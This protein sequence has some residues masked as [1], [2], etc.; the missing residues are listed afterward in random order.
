MRRHLMLIILAAAPALAGCHQHWSYAALKGAQV[1]LPDARDREWRMRRDRTRAELLDVQVGGTQTLLVANWW[2]DDPAVPDDEWT[3][4]FVV[5]L[6]DLKLGNHHVSPDNGRLIENSA[7]RKARKPYAGLEGRVTII[8]VGERSITADCALY[9]VPF[10]QTEP[11][12]KLR[13]MHAFEIVGP[14][15]AELTR[16][17]INAEGGAL[18]PGEP[19]EPVAEPAP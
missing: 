13:G 14:G 16:A 3:R 10:E 5:V 19:T 8:G 17:C 11:E 7:W 6:D 9:T 2:K 4:A 15:S 12:W 1:S 18:P